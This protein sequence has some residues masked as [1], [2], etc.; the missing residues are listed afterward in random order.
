[1]CILRCDGGYEPSGCHIIRYS[2]REG[3]WNHDVPTCQ[4]E[5]PVSGRTLAA[6]GTGVAAVVGTGVAAVVGTGVAAV[7]I[8]PVVL[9]GAGFTATGVAA[10][11]IAAML[12]T[13]LTAV[14]SWFALSQS[15][16]VVGTALVTKC[17]L[18]GGASVITYTTLGLLSK[19]EK[20]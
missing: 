4:K 12:Q 16:G 19:C 6:V 14:G 5:W 17:A 13:P 18:G 7:V 8:P 20:E 9:A 11:S 1:M 2:H 10:G 3:N 15:A